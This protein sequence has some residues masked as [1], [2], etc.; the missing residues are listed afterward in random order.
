MLSP[1]DGNWIPLLP[2]DRQIMEITGMDEK[3]YRAFMRETMLRHGIKPGDPVAFDP[4]T[5]I[6]TLVIGIALSALASLLSPKPRQQ[7]QGQ[8]EQSLLLEL[9]SAL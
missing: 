8:I 1:N 2:Q 7:K 6:V 5:L 3:Q 9:R 4:I